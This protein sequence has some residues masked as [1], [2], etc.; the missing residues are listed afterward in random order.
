MYYPLAIFHQDEISDISTSVTL[1]LT[2][3][4]II[5][6]HRN[7]LFFRTIHSWWVLFLISFLIVYWHL[8]NT[9]ILISVLD[10][11]WWSDY[12]DIT[13]QQKIHSHFKLYFYQSISIQMK[14]STKCQFSV[15]TNDYSI[16]NIFPWIIYWPYSTKMRFLIYPLV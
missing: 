15:K 8:F 12:T 2:P 4:K 16:H 13:S 7:D 10:I 6:S 5:V 1:L 14:L 3:S 9:I 11:K